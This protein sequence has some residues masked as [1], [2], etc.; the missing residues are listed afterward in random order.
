[1]CLYNKLINLLFSKPKYYTIFM[2][3]AKGIY[4]FMA[5]RRGLKKYLGIYEKE[6]TD[7]MC[8]VINKGD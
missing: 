3:P 6:Q 7:F 2:G 8:K 5:I 4:L 1:M